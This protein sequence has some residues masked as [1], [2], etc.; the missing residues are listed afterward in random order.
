MEPI[1]TAFFIIAASVTCSSCAD[2][3]RYKGDTAYQWHEGELWSCREPDAFWLRNGKRGNCR[4]DSWW[5][6]GGIGLRVDDFKPGSYFEDPI[7]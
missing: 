2:P 3:D 4:P 7:E 5:D 1:F 6:D